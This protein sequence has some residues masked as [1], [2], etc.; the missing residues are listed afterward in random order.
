MAWEGDWRRAR[1]AATMMIVLPIALV[2][3]L[4]RFADQVEWSTAAL[5]VLA[6]DLAVLATVCSY[7]WAAATDRRAGASAGVR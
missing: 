6:T 5:W 7:L 2:V 1:L 4:A 3:Q